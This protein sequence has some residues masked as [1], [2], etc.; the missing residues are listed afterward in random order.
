MTAA[1]ISPTTDDVFTVLGAFIQNVIGGGVPVTRGIDNLVPM[2]PVNPGFIGMTSLFM[3]PQATNVDSYDT[4]NPAPTE[5]SSLRSTRFDIQIDCLGAASAS[6]ATILTT[7]L[8]DEFGCTA[9]APNCQPLYCEDARMMAL[10]DAEEQYEERWTFTAAL[11]YEPT[12][13]TPMLFSDT[14]AV[15]VISVTNEY[16]PT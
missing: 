8:R 2:P 3:I 15:G 9:L 12:V 11:D 1:T 14:L 7:L 6:W 16:P 13:V 4:T 5:V 10:T